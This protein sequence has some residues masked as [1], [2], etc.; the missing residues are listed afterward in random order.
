M[1]NKTDNPSAGAQGG[2]EYAIGDVLRGERATLGKS[3]LDVQRDLRIKAAFISAI[4]DA[5]I[6]AF[7]NQ[8]VIPG[9]VRSYSRYLNLDPEEV[10]RRFCHDSGY[11]AAPLTFGQT[12]PKSPRGAKGTPIVAPAGGFPDFPLTRSVGFAL[13]RVP[14]AAIGS[15]LVLIGL[16]AGLGY[17]GWTVLR[18]IQR[19]Q[20]APVDEL[21]IAVAEVETITPPSATPLA[22]PALTDLSSPVA[23]TALADLY[24]HQEAE[25]KIL[26]PR[27]GPIAAIDPDRMGLLVNRTPSPPALVPAVAPGDTRAEAIL[28]TVAASIPASGIDGAAAES[29]AAGMRQTVDPAA[30]LVVVAERAA[31]VRVYLEN[32]TIIFERILEKGET[33]SPP[34]GVG[35]PLIWAGNSGSVYVKVGSELHGPLGNGTKAAR[36]VV[37]APQAIADRYDVVSEIPEVISQAFAPKAATPVIQ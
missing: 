21:P 25:V 24:R 2:Y 9:Y 27:D 17:G 36:G 32:G 12:K 3:L 10:F 15:V 19:V 30:K 23:A 31:W 7:P 14:V 37:L 29:T 35:A 18:N 28:S 13:P 16:V 33:Y 11:V 26:V 22:E 8:G 1:G 6:T 4:E 5:D 34:E 20:F